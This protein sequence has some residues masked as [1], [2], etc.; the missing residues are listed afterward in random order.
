MYEYVYV[1]LDRGKGGGDVGDCV[2]VYTYNF[3]CVCVHI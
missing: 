2:S 3:V 1:C